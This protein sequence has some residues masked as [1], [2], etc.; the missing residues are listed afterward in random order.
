MRNKISL[1]ISVVDVVNY[2]LQQNKIPFIQSFKIQNDADVTYENVEIKIASSPEI[3]LPFTKHIDYISANSSL[4]VKD[5]SP[6]LN[7]EYLGS[8]TER[9]VGVLTV[10]ITADNEELYS[11]QRHITALAFDQWQ[12]S[13]YFPDLIGAYITPNHPEITKIKVRASQ[14]WEKWTGSPSFTAYQTQDPNRVLTQAAAFYGAVQEQ[15]LVYS[16]S[17]AGLHWSI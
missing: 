8:L 5:I 16:V 17:P 10:S 13:E 12:G 14:L 11:E 9:V 4:S 3:I 2:A 7:T 6:L 15:N 1:N